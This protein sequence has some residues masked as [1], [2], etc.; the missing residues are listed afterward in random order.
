MADSQIRYTG[1]RPGE[2]LHEA[3]FGEHE[4]RLPTAHPAHLGHAAR[5]G[6]PPTSPTGSTSC[7]GPLAATTATR[8]AALLASL[9]AGL[10]RGRGRGGELAAA[11]LA[12]YPDEF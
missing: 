6:S 10:R 8:Y 9:H 4:E 7:T 1:L 3:L 5:P 12:S 11:A 2:K